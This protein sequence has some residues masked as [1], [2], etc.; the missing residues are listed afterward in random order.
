MLNNSSLLWV[1]VEKKTCNQ[2]FNFVHEFNLS[3]F[4][5]TVRV[6]LLFAKKHGFLLSRKLPRYDRKTY[7]NKEH[8]RRSELSL[9]SIQLT[10][11]VVFDTTRG[12]LLKLLNSTNH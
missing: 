11:S 12:F 6:S 8:L 10:L 1:L 5:L 4:S 7:K 2:A 9:A 3:Q